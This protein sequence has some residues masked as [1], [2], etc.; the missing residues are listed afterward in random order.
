MTRRNKV[1]CAHIRERSEEKRYE[2]KTTGSTKMNN[3]L[4]SNSFGEEWRR[5]EKRAFSVGNI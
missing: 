1:S 3:K 5:G 4:N 2:E